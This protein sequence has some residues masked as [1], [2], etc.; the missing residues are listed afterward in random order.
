MKAGLLYDQLGAEEYGIL[1]AADRVGVQVEA[2]N[3]KTL[4][5]SSEFRAS[6]MCTLG[7]V[8]A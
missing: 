6:T 7:G 2:L 4:L 3:A 8:R 1:L 5:F